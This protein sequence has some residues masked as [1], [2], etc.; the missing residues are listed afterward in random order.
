MEENL[1]ILIELK[2]SKNKAIAHGFIYNKGIFTEPKAI[3]VTFNCFLVHLKLF[4]SFTKVNKAYCKQLI[5]L[6]RLT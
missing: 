3:S 6:S 2:Y 5:I 4:N 1:G